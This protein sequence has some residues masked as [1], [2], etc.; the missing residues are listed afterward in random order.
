MKKILLLLFFH[1]SCI[2]FAFAQEAKEIV[3]KADEKAKGK[4]SISTITI[5][6]IR[7]NWTREMKVKAWTKCNELTLLLVLATAREKGVVY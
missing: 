1:L 5:Q 3:K 4:T 2:P 6:T 7:P